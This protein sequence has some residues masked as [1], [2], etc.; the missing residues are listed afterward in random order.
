MD[1]HR[2]ALITGSAGLVG[3]AC[4]EFLSA[5]GWEIVG[6]DNDMRQAFFGPQGSTAGVVERLANVL[7][8]YRHYPDDIRDRAKIRTI[9]RDERPDFIIHTAAQPSHDRAASLPYDDFDVNATGTLNILVAARDFCADSPICFTSTNKVYGDRPNMLKLVEGDT[10]YDYADGRD[11]IDES[12]SIDT[13]LHSLFGASKVA[14]DVLCQEFG[15]YFGMPVGI[16]RCSCLTGP[17]H[18]AVELHGFLTYIVMCATRRAAYTIHGYKG[19]Q[20]R[21]QIHCDDVAALFLEYYRRPRAGEVYNLGGGRANSLS[22][23]E[24]ID[25]LSTMGFPLRYTIEERNRIGDH[26]C[27]IS[28]LAKVR[29]HY[30]G[31]SMTY[32]VRQCIED[33]VRYHDAGGGRLNAAPA[34]VAFGG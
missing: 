10:R 8:Q 29:S 33:I 19:K 3:S 9:F 12:L 16:F 20:V 32:D 34:T 5:Q 23:L 17:Q 24:T 22:V 11:G 26:I 30:P 14:A 18:A 21:D 1:R 31:W 2:K 6:I 25:I 13:C 7:P 15:R 27:Y 4:A 28:D